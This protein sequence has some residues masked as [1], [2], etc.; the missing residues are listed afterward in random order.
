MLRNHLC[1]AKLVMITSTK[2]PKIQWVHR[3]QS[4]P[5]VRRTERAFVVEGV[6]L[7]EEATS[8]GIVPRL[9]LHTEEISLRGRSLLDRL[10][11]QGVEVAAVAPHVMKA[12][13]DT[14]SPQGLLIVLPLPDEVNLKPH[15]FVLVL[16]GV[17]DPGN[18]GTILRT[19]AAV[20]VGV[21]LLASESADPYAPKVLRAAMGAHFKLAIQTLPWKGIRAFLEIPV[22]DVIPRVYLA[23]T[24]QGTPFD[25]ADYVH[26]VALILGGEA[27]GA[28]KA[29]RETAHTQIQIPMVGEVESLNVAVAAGI[30]LYEVVRQRGRAPVSVK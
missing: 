30:L 21:T 7:C 16:D 26:P 29:A 28:S 22:D 10:T 27:A 25:Q 12:A 18:L 19:A 14:Q 2:N 15:D 20:G 3:L 11:A 24:R 8:A 1:F 23:S 9:A 6:R 5:R 13:S 4:R 17:R